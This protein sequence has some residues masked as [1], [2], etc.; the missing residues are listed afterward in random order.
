[1]AQKHNENVQQEAYVGGKADIAVIVQYRVPV[2]FEVICAHLCAHLR[3][4]KTEQLCERI[5]LI[6]H[7]PRIGALYDAGIHK[8]LDIVRRA[9]GLDYV[10]DAEAVDHV[11]RDELLVYPRKIRVRH[12]VADALRYAHIVDIQIR[13]AHPD[14]LHMAGIGGFD[15][16]VLLGT[17]RDIIGKDARRAE[18]RQRRRNN[19]V[20]L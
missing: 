9:I 8:R 2:V 13:K 20:A 5:A 17:G 18:Q 14:V 19:R 4:L 3:N 15:A 11:L 16:P 7:K 10:I 12:L 6:P 1:M